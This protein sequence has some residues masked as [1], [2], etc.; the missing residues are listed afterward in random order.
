MRNKKFSQSSAA[1]RFKDHVYR[2]VKVEGC[3]S[4]HRLHYI[5]IIIGWHKSIVSSDWSD[6]MVWFGQIL[7][8]LTFTILY[9]WSLVFRDELPDMFLLWNSICIHKTKIGCEIKLWFQTPLNSFSV[10]NVQYLNTTESVFMFF[11]RT[12]QLI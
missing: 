3:S 10:S 4:W 1:A 12:F 7:L 5:H 11:H 6:T 2:M 9:T 8:Y